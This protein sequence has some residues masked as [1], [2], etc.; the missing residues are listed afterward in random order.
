[1]VV[2]PAHSRV[3]K[4][5][6]SLATIAQGA[7]RDTGMAQRVPVDIDEFARR[8]GL[9]VQEVTLGE[10]VA[11]VESCGIELRPAGVLRQLK[12]AYIRAGCIDS[13]PRVLVLARQQRW[14]RRFIIAHEVAH[15][16][17]PQPAWIGLPPIAIIGPKLKIAGNEYVALQVKRY[18]VEVDGIARSLLM[19]DFGVSARQLSAFGLAGKYG[20]PV[21]EV[22]NQALR[23]DICPMVLFTCQYDRHTGRLPSLPARLSASVSPSARTE[24]LKLIHAVRSAALELTDFIN[25]CIN[26]RRV[27]S[28][29]VRFDRR[30]FGI[31]VY[32]DHLH[33]RLFVLAADLEHQAAAGLTAGLFRPGRETAR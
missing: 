29:R 9:V 21:E 32:N 1:M 3:P 6:R 27:R 8:Q 15:H 28:F 23:L 26:D 33:G 10:L 7:L 20:V 17:Y 24:L 31:T 5:E 13:R 11:T 16:L 25:S 4:L 30:A 12:G 19:P 22:F 2:R 18:E 14:N